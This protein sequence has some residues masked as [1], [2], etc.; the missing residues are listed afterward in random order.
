M[1]TDVTAG[2][3]SEGIYTLSTP[4][5]KAVLMEP[6]ATIFSHLMRWSLDEIEKFAKTGF[7]DR[8]H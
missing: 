1:A 5:G 4:E 8:A 3:I 7:V 6:T 2:P